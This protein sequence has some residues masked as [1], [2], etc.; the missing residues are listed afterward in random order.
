M[1]HPCNM[2][3]SLDINTHTYKCRCLDLWD[4]CRIW[5]S[6][7]EID[8]YHRGYILYLHLVAIQAKSLSWTIVRWWWWWI[9]ESIKENRQKW[10]SSCIIATIH[11]LFH[12]FNSHIY[13][14]FWGVF[15]AYYHIAHTLTFVYSYFF[16]SVLSYD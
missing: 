11:A 15:Q 6:L 4:P 12:E 10:S 1:I 13:Y 2:F 16:S 8:L 7:K 3:K 14:W 9:F 5:N